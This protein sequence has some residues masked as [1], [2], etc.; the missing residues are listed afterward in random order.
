MLAARHL[1]TARSG[2]LDLSLAAGE[3]LA[4][5]GPSGA[6]K[7]LLLRALADLDPVP[8]EVTLDGRDRAAMAAPDWRRQVTFVPAESAFWAPR[9]ADHL[10]A[11]PETRDNARAL[12]LDPA[13]LEAPVERLSTGERQ[14]GALL[15][16][17]A[18]A[19]RVLLL[20]EP[21]GPLDAATTAR[22][23]QVLRS[24][25]ARGGALVLVTHDED[26]A[27]RLGCRVMR[28]P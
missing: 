15:R 13:L 1:S 21:T 26:Q 16:A 27:R 19:P 10:P 9:L 4:V 23:E 25:L 11:G 6:G 28:L 14:R 17:L 24:Y 12:G 22:V 7:T 18:G 2:P 3:A 5:L 8:G 20:D